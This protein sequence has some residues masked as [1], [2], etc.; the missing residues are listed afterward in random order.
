MIQSIKAS[1]YS[2]LCAFILF[3]K[4]KYFLPWKLCERT[5]VLRLQKKKARSTFSLPSQ[6]QGTCDIMVLILVTKLLKHDVTVTW[7]CVTKD[8][9]DNNKYKSPA[10]DSLSRALIQ[11]AGYSFTASERNCSRI[12]IKIAGKPLLTHCSHLIVWCVSVGS[13]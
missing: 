12:L 10:T 7:N 4:C 9:N 13:V 2:L 8:T 11:K 5:K 6:Q 3:Y 1:G